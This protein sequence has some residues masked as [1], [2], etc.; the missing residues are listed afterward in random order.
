MR[1]TL[2]FLND[3]EEETIVKTDRPIVHDDLIVFFTNPELAHSALNLAE[4]EMANL[5]INF[6]EVSLVC[7]ILY[8][9]HMIHHKDIDDSGRIINS[10]NVIFDLVKATQISMPVQYKE[11]L[12]SF[13]DH[14]TFNKEYASFFTENNIGRNFMEDAVLWCVGTVVCKSKILTNNCYKESND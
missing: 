6:K 9:L 12:Y 1:Y 5:N 2:Y 14:L 13:A 3:G 10:L 8:I 11:A 4:P 7:N